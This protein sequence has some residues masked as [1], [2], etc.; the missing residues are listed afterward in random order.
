MDSFGRDIP[1]S[2]QYNPVILRN[3]IL[4]AIPAYQ[5]LWGPRSLA[6]TNITISGESYLKCPISKF[7]KGTFLNDKQ[8]TSYEQFP[9]FCFNWQW[10][11]LSYFLRSGIAMFRL[12][13]LLIYASITRSWQNTSVVP[14]IAIFSHI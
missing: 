5:K 3:M 2:S 13:C 4:L 14:G 11:E 1:T 10:T 12:V 8:V 9:T 7:F 6:S